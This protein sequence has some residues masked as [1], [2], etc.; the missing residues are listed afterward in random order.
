MSSTRVAARAGLQPSDARKGWLRSSTIWWCYLFMVPALILSALFTFYPMVMSWWFSFLDWN[1][2]TQRGDFIGL[3]N[4][5]ELLR[6][7]Q[8]WN[9][10]GRSML[11]VL[12]GTPVRVL[13]ALLIAIL[14]NNQMLKLAPVFRTFIFIPVV[15]T[16]AVVGVVMSFMLGSYQGPVNQ[17]LMA[18]HLVDAPV[19]F[20]SDPQVALWTILSVHVWKSTGQTMIYWLAALQTVPVTYYEAAKVDGAGAFRLIRHITWPILMPFAI[21]IIVLTVQSDLHTFALVQAMT[22]GGPY[23]STQVMEVYIYQTAFAAGS[24]ESG[25]A[26]MARLGYAS[27]AGC[28]FGLATLVIALAQAW[29]FRK[30]NQVRGQLR[31]SGDS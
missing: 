23:F 8:F 26:G 17:V 1:G 16:A 4:Y 15:T 19:K 30:V 2:F 12:V 13:L 6:D 31:E 22:E 11:F 20:L 21:V 3:A 28:F 29:A 14:L 7:Q 27:A 9:A 24:S 18:L 5:W 10:F 25:N